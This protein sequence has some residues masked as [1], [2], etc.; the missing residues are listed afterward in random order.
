MNGLENAS[1]I[2]GKDATCVELECRCFFYKI[3]M[4]IASELQGMVWCC[5]VAQCGGVVWHI[6]A[7]CGGI[8]WRCVVAVCGSSVWCGVLYNTGR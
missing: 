6:V 2:Q 8:G 4:P 7:V 3:T 5:G 1:A